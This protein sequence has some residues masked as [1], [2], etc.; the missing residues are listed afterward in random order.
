M[1]EWQLLQDEELN[2]FSYDERS[3]VLQCNGDSQTLDYPA[4]A[5]LYVLLTH[6]D[7]PVTPDDFFE[8]HIETRGG[9]IKKA[10]DTLK[11]DKYVG[12]HIF[13][14]GINKG[15]VYSFLT[16]PHDAELLQSRMNSE[17][18]ILYVVESRPGELPQELKTEAAKKH[19]NALYRVGVAA[20]AL[21][22]A[23]TTAYVVVKH[24]RKRS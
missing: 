19:A 21:A 16:N 23:A 15:A 12:P 7:A 1:H 22:A 20:G 10:M 8:A 5:L 18:E 17:H 11:K 2:R 14:S 13:Q 4:S 3:G 9:A 24:V 6:A